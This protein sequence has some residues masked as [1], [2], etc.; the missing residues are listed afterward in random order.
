MQSFKDIKAELAQFGR[1]PNKNYRGKGEVLDY[2][3]R[4]EI[5]TNRIVYNFKVQGESD[6]YKVVLVFGD[7]TYTDVKDSKHTMPAKVSSSRYGGGGRPKKM[8][9]TKP[10][11]KNKLMIRSSD[12]DFR[13][14]FMK[15]LARDRKS[16]V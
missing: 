14:R 4:H 7:V 8:Y 1:T 11:I 12:P 13:F 3:V 9:Y 16:V 2:E 15:E 5:G 10:N 6:V